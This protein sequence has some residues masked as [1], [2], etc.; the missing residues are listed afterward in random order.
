MKSIIFEGSKP[1]RHMKKKLLTIV[2]ATLV[3]SIP[4]LSVEKGQ[5]IS[6]V[7]KDHS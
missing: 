3:F 4:L 1:V 6:H 7:L 5:S 2:F